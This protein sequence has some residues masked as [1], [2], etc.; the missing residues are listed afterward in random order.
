M[1]EAASIGGGFY[2]VAIGTYQVRRIAVAIVRGNAIADN[3]IDEIGLN[4]EVSV[5]VRDVGITRAW[6]LGCA[7]TAGKDFRAGAAVG[8]SIVKDRGISDGDDPVI[9]DA[10]AGQRGLVLTDRGVDHKDGADAAIEDSPTRAALRDGV[11]RVAA[12]DDAVDLIE[13]DRRFGDGQCVQI[14]H[15]AT[16]LLGGVIAD[17]RSR[18]RHVAAGILDAAAGIGV[19]RIV[20]HIGVVY[21]RKSEKVAYA[22][23]KWSR[24]VAYGGVDDV[25]LNEVR[26]CSGHSRCL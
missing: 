23:A 20:I 15:A 21:F 26:A 2:I 13:I 19:S 16:G 25:G 17:G 9:I 4:K 8:H 10:A 11:S 1:G 18:N 3:A 7:G 24:V 14:I 22:A 6:V 12:S 5:A